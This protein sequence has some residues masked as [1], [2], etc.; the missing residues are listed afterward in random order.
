MSY[1]EGN[2]TILKHRINEAIR[3]PQVRLIDETGEMLGVMS[4]TEA[5]K[6]AQDK[7]LDLVE[8]SPDANPPVCKLMDYGKFKFQAQKKEADTKKK[9]HQ[10]TIKEIQLRPNIG[11]GD[12]SIKIK[13]ILKFL[14]EGDKVKVLV[15]FKGREVSN[16]EFGQRLIDKIKEN[17]GDLGVCETIPRADTKQMGLI[18]SPHKKGK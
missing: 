4:I 17:V 11:S 8:M 9:Q 13:S 14:E 1:L 15:R 12:L 18:I 5:L 3:V 2:L 7:S 16:A 6:I 10:Q